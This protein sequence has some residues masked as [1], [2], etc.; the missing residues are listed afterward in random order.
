MQKQIKLSPLERLLILM[1]EDRADLL[2]LVGYNIIS[3]ILYLAVPLSAQA[4][5]NT[6]AAGVLIQP[7]VVLSIMVFVALILI[8]ILKLIQNTIIERLQQRIFA[9]IALRLADH[10][11]RIE[12]SSLQENYAPEMANRFFDTVTLQKTWAKLLTDVPS[13]VLQILVGLVLMGIYSPFLFGFD[14]MFLL[15]ALLISWLGINGVGTSINESSRKYRLAGWLEELGRCHISLK[16]NASPDYF[17]KRL[18][19]EVVNYIIARR[20]HFA[21]VVKQV[22]SSHMLQAV[23]MTV[24]LASGGWLVIEGQLTLGQLVAAELVMMMMLAAIEKLAN[25]ID[26]YYDLLTSL[27]KIGAI[28]DLPVEEMTGVELSTDARGARID[29]QQLSFAYLPTHPILSSVNL[30]IEAGQRVSLVGESGCG[31]TTLAHL[32]AGLQKPSHGRILY[33]GYDLREVHLGSLRQNIALVSGN[34]EIFE[35]TIEDNIL[36]GRTHI[37]RTHL[38]RAIDLANLDKSL[39]AFPKGLQTNL[40]SEGLNISIGE[41]LRILIARA[42]IKNPRLLILDD[43]FFGIDEKTKLKILSNLLDPALPWTVLDISHDPSIVMRSEI[44]H[45]LHQGKITESDAPQTLLKQPDSL[46]VDLFPELA[47]RMNVKAFATKAG[48]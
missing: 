17:V 35:G 11:P 23:A 44:V 8:G 30:Q 4:L 43:V 28:T 32:L 5:I 7:L 26:D 31:K 38:H 29:C 15:G 21:I 33:N 18:D 27:V 37:D 9:R 45:V 16:M 39:I 48:R 12:H 14:L 6:I 25:S 20:Q 46:F 36:M 41:R 10:L 40:I 34:N 1:N 24:V 42:I 13:A 2:A 22:F 19:S 3:G 47:Q